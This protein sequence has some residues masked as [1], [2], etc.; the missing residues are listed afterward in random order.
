[1]SHRFL[2]TILL[3]TSADNIFLGIATIIVVVVVIPPI[4]I[5]VPVG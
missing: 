4:G 1:M 5:A 3:S 2:R